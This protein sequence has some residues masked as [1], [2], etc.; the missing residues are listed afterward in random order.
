MDIASHSIRRQLRAHQVSD[1]NLIHVI[2]QLPQ[3]SENF[4]LESRFAEDAG[5]AQKHHLHRQRWQECLHARHELEEK[6][7]NGPR[8]HLRAAQCAVLVEDA[9]KYE[10]VPEYLVNRRSSIAGVGE[11]ESWTGKHVKA[12][13]SRSIM[14]SVGMAEALE[15]SEDERRGVREGVVEA[16]WVYESAREA[17][18]VTA[19]KVG[20]WEKAAV[21]IVSGPWQVFVQDVSVNQN[22]GAVGEDY[23]DAVA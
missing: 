12:A 3:L 1:D 11:E 2:H 8:Q 4:Q 6:P 15:V 19:Q 7:S 5:V 22:A 18:I 10:H 13:A 16:L 23:G 21:H 9:A 14:R 17:V 20:N